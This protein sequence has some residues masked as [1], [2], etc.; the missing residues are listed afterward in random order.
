MFNLPD[1]CPPPPMKYACM[2]AC[3]C[4]CV[5]GCVCDVCVCVCA[6]TRVCARAMCVVCVHMRACP[7]TYLPIPSTVVICHPSTEYSGHK[8]YKK[9]YWLWCNILLLKFKI[10]NTSTRDMQGGQATWSNT[11]NKSNL[12]HIGCISIRWVF[13]CCSHNCIIFS[14][15]SIKP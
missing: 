1:Q 4:A 14:C 13:Y 2:H 5:C 12:C 9:Y 15:N 3:V 7:S 10:H 6:C 8:H 11:W